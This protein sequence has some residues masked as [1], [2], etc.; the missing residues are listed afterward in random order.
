MKKITCVIVFLLLFSFCGC[1]NTNSKNKDYYEK[2]NLKKLAKDE[3]VIIF[4]Y[5][6]N[7]NTDELIEYFSDDI[8]NTHNLQSEW[9]SFYE[10]INGDIQNYNEISFTGEAMSINK[11]GQINDS[12]LT[13]VFN[14]VVTTENI[15][16]EIGYYHQRISKEHPK[17]KGINLFTV[18]IRDDKG[19]IVDSCSVGDIIIY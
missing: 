9:E 6:K 12:H 8:K 5:I 19:Y 17:S 15:V 1:S 7:K 16:Y 3:A 2:H 4:E 18:N 10:F 13:V 11:E 14:N